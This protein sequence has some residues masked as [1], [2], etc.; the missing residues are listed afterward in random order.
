MGILMVTLM[1]TLQAAFRLHQRP[2]ANWRSSRP[3]AGRRSSAIIRSLP[4]A[5]HTHQ[6]D[7]H[8]IRAAFLHPSV[9]AASGRSSSVRAY[10]AADLFSAAER[11]VVALLKAQSSSS[12]PIVTHA[13]IMQER[14]KRK[15]PK[16]QLVIFSLSLGSS[17]LF[18]DLL[19]VPSFF[20]ID[21]FV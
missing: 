5:L 8:S 6:P 9:P 12:A 19:G 10:A 11:K 13:G 1:V 2:H 7:R 20:P 14:K 18:V 3:T 4:A 17:G 15:N 16:W 21:G